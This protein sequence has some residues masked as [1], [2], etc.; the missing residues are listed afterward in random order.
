MVLEASTLICFQCCGFEAAAATPTW[1]QLH[2][3]ECCICHTAFACPKSISDDHDHRP[4]RRAHEKCMASELLQGP[5]VT[6]HS[7]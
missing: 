5:R 3:I 7:S 1:S 2:K 4:D 6:C